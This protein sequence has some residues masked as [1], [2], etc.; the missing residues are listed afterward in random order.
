RFMF[1]NKDALNFSP[2]K[3]EGLN[4]YNRNI[5]AEFNLASAKNLWTGKAMF[6]KSFTPGKS[7]DDF[8]YAGD[9]KYNKANFF[10]QW[11]QE[12]VGSN[13]TAEVGYVPNSAR[14]GYYKIS[15]N[16]GYLFFIKS[17][18]IISHGP[19]LVTNMYWD[20]R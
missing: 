6:L 1:V 19:K 17:P 11:Q 13:Y 4:R 7:S 8:V 5:G 10:W 18:K 12:Y 2:E 15:P 20:K 3:Y 16:V 14:M 9:L